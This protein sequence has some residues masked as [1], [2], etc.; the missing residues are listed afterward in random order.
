MG[1]ILY[2][3]ETEIFFTQAEE[4]VNLLKG[5]RLIEIDDDR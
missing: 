4:G 2:K 3:R 1:S 5:S